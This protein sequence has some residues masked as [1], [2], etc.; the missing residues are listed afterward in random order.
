MIPIERAVI[1][2]RITAEKINDSYK[3]IPEVLTLMVCQH[4]TNVFKETFGSS[5]INKS[6]QNKKTDY[7]RVISFPVFQSQIEDYLNSRLFEL[8]HGFFSRIVYPR[9]SSDEL[10]VLLYFPTAKINDAS[11]SNAHRHFDNLL[12][13]HTM[14]IDNFLDKLR[15]DAFQFAADKVDQSLEEAKKEAQL[16]LKEEKR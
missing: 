10:K 12:L 5:M 11:Y 15:V 13:D 16:L 7:V 3:I 14:E 6:D 2:Q 9:L 1:C 8:V 4:V